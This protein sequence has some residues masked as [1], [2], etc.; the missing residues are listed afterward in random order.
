MK[1]LVYNRLNVNTLQIT[2]IFVKVK[3]CILLFFLL[4]TGLIHNHLALSIKDSLIHETSIFHKFYDDFVIRCVASF[5][6][7]IS[8]F[9]EK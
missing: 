5:L 1:F 8:N 3:V 7:D 9:S 4:I 2:S 6:Y